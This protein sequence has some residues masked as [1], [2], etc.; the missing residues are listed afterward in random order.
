MDVAKPKQ[1][2]LADS[3]G[4][5]R[6]KMVLMQV[7]QHDGIDRTRLLAIAAIDTFKEINIVAG[8]TT[9]TVIALLGLY[10]DCQR[11]ADG[12]A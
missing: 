11:R 2:F 7:R 5:A 4:G 9:R 8:G 1:I 12:F 6:L 3:P 10:R